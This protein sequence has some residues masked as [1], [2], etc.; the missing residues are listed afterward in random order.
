M[1]A[2]LMCDSCTNLFSV[3]ERG[4]R[5]LQERIPAIENNAFN[6]GVRSL[7]TCAACAGG[8]GVK[9]PSVGAVAELEARPAGTDAESVEEDDGETVREHV[10]RIR[11]EYPMR[12]GE[13]TAQYQR[14]LGKLMWENG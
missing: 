13:T 6:N 1:S 10:V 8:N 5:E 12:D 14:R 11:G 7:H 9:R 3:N 4:W 2:V